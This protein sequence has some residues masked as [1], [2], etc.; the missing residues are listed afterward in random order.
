MV[1]CIGETGFQFAT[2][3]LWFL[4]GCSGG[5]SHR[6]RVIEA[7]YQTLMTGGVCRQLISLTWSAM[8]RV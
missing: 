3:R 8:P 7:L 6:I 2:T 5:L 4:A 1:V